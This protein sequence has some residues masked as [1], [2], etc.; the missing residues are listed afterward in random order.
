MTSETEEVLPP[1]VILHDTLNHISSIISVAQLCL[2]NKE[3]SP[4]IQHDL[5]RIVA[6]TKQVAANL[7]RLAETL[8]EEEEA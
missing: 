7:K 4:E 3:V 6:M 5:K 2:I 8:E 1:G